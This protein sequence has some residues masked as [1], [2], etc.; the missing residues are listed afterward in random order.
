VSEAFKGFQTENLAPAVQKAMA[1]FDGLDDANKVNDFAKEWG[2]QPK[3][4]ETQ[5]GQQSQT[6]QIV[7]AVTQPAPGIAPGKL[8]DAHLLQQELNEAVGRGASQ[9]EQAQIMAKHGL[10]VTNGGQPIAAPAAAAPAPA[11]Q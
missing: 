8:G 5:Q 9:A 11:T 4:A 3:P 2:L 7:G 10:T 6:Q 1:A